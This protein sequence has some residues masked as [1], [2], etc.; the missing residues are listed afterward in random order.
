MINYRQNRIN[1][2]KEINFEYI[3]SELRDGKDV[4]VQFS[5]LTFS[6]AILSQLDKLCDKYDSNF[7]VRFYGNYSGSF[8]FK[9]LLKIPHVKYLSVD[10]MINAHNILVISE[11][12]YLKKLS[13][14][15]FELKET[16]ILNL[17]NLKKLKELI[18]T[19]T[20]TKAL[21]LDYLRDYKNLKLLII[22]G[23]TK[24]IDAVGEI[25]GLEFLSLNSVKR[26]SISFVNKLINLKT[27]KLILG[28]R[29]NINEL[30]KIKLKISKLFG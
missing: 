24:N 11:L 14:G 12:Q 3:D 2:P 26:V 18:L 23:H 19:D 30:M 28:S 4:I 17:S 21:N 29:N 1:N 20:K 5:D 25:V 10:C 22:C 13:L 9:T 16:E 6:D 27:L 15:V 7:G 8:D